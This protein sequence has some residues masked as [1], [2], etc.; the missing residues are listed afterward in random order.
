MLKAENLGKKFGSNWVFRNLSFTT[1]QGESLLVIGANGSGKSTLLRILAGLLSPTEGRVTRD[2]QNPQTQLGYASL[3]LR[4]YPHLTAREHLQVAA[5]LRGVDDRSDEL[6]A[7]VGLDGANEKLT[8]H[9][10]TGMRARLKFALALQ[11]RP[12]LLILDEP[13]A[14][15]D[16]SGK[17][18]VQTLVEAQRSIGACILASNDARDISLA[19]HEIRLGT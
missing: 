11:T 14:S 2:A 6:L 1:R 16:E 17:A 10:S 18:L 9:Y 3:D 5:R 13:T 12:P 19:T 7:L 15:L 4:L 8:A